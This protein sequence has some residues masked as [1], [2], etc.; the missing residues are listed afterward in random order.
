MLAASGCMSCRWYTYRAPNSRQYTATM[1]GTTTGGLVET[2]TFAGLARIRLRKV[3][4]M[5]NTAS[6]MRLI[7]PLADVVYDLQARICTPLPRPL[8]ANKPARSRSAWVITH[9]E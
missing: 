7:T 9:T 3:Q 6:A 5:K 4:N 8:L 2:Y 1:K